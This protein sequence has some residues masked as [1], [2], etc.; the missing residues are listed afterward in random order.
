M[1][2]DCIPWTGRFDSDGYPHRGRFEKVHR[3]IYQEHIGLI[4]DGF[5]V[6]HLCNNRGCINPEHLHA[7]SASEHVSTHCPWESPNHVFEDSLRMDALQ[8]RSRV[9]V[10]EHPREPFRAK[11]S[12]GLATVRRCVEGEQPLVHPSKAKGDKAELEVQA[13]LRELLG[14]PARRAL[15]AGRLDDIGDIDGVSETCVSVTNRQDVAAAVR[16]KPIEAEMQRRR[17]GCTF[18]ATF[19]RLRG[20]EYR[21]VLTPEQWA[22]YWREAR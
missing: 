8:P 5:H 19:V 14:V 18:A 2:S 11:G 9:H 16:H 20:G 1:L 13:L 22:T 21:V 7:L 10:G 12:A 15:G 4:P 3:A 17:R 6:H